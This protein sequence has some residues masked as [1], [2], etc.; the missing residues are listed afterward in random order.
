MILLL[1]CLAAHAGLALA[2]PSP[3]WVP[4]LTVIGLVLSVRRHAGRWLLLSA[5]S[6]WFAMAWAIRWSAPVFLG[7][8]LAGAG[9]RAAGRHWD[10]SDLRVELFLAGA[11]C[12]LLDAGA[13]W[14]GWTW[15]VRLAG[16]ALARTAVTCAALPLVRSLAAVVERRTR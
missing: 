8:L 14:L 9:V 7:V 16:L 3:W 5:I 11:A 2:V 13:F 6:G 15:S 4:D 10:A 12:L 1:A